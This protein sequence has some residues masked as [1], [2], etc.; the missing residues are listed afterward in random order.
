MCFQLCQRIDTFDYT[1]SLV[2]KRPVFS[3]IHII[4]RVAFVLL[5]RLLL[6]VVDAILVYIA[7][8]IAKAIRERILEAVI[9][10]TIVILEKSLKT[11]FGAIMRGLATISDIKTGHE[12]L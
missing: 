7:G 1:P 2:G 4:R 12:S 3:Q 10:R 11:P 6:V 8:E 5:Y 9:K